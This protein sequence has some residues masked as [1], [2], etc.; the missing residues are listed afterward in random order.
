M[1]V[2]RLVDLNPRVKATYFN[3]VAKDAEMVTDELKHFLKK[4][5][6]AVFTKG[7]HPTLVKS[8]S[9]QQYNTWAM[10]QAFRAAGFEVQRAFQRT[11]NLETNLLYDTHK[12]WMTHP[13]LKTKEGDF[14]LI[15]S[16]S[17]NGLTR[18][19]ISVGFFRLVCSNG[20]VIS[21]PGME[22]FNLAITRLHLEVNQFE[23]LETIMS[24]IDNVKY[25]RQTVDQMKHRV[26]TPEEQREFAEKAL[27]IRFDEE[28]FTSDIDQMLEV[29][30]PE[31]EG[32]NLWLIFNRVQERLL[33]GG[34]EVTNTEKDKTQKAQAIRGG[35]KDFEINEKLGQLASSYLQMEAVA[36]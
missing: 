13:D 33:K 23:L 34:F 25:A 3:P 26:M 16:N 4:N 36:N 19:R 24:H 1:S 18:F 32:D 5:A 6:P 15:I 2:Q 12:I 21:V 17:H 14:Q 35:M 8:D 31:D 30:R 27:R 11:S 28:R 9:Y 7:T 10:I 20:L 22:E 29:L